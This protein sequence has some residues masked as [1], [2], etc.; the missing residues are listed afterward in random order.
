MEVSGEAEAGD[1]GDGVDAG[2]EVGV[3]SGFGGVS[4]EGHHLFDGGVPVFLGDGALLVCA[5]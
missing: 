1:V 4:V 2:G 3:G 5:D